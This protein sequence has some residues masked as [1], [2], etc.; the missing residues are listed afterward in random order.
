MSGLT[1]VINHSIMITLFVF[2]M[3]L[4]IDYVNVS[5]RG[6]LEKTMKGGKWRQYA[7]AS[8]LGS[9]P[10]CL[11]AFMNVSFYVHGLL[12][13]GAIAGGM[14]ATSGD[15]A[16][17]MLALFPRQAILLFILLFVI[18]IMGG[19]VSDKLV[20]RLGITTCEDCDLQ[21]VHL[22]TDHR[23]FDLTALKNFSRLSPIR[24]LVSFSLLII[25]MALV[26]GY[27]GPH[28]WNWQRLTIVALL[29]VAT[30]IIL[31]TSDH[32]LEAH[33]WDHIIKRHLW[34]VFLWTFFALLFIHIGLSHWNFEE[35]VKTHMLWIF[36]VCALVGLIPESGPHMVFVMMFAHGLVPF[37]ILLTSSIVQDG[38][39]MLPMFSYSVKDAILIKIF[40][41]VIAVVIG[42]PLLLIGI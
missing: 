32:Y 10:G 2:V 22:E 42:L 9:T 23:L 26:L 39:G 4:I 37:S 30:F 38:H 25:I 20:S 5:T 3:M 28:T 1:H 33:I 24:Y 31:T 17:V 18:G 15:E 7:T 36:L 11:G 12:S 27:V 13:F 8:F 41:L 34:Q 19:F 40:N 16:F 14:I 21:V 35:F 6:N 29:F